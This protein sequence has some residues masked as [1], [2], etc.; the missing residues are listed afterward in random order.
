MLDAL[1]NMFSRKIKIRA[2]M[3][4][5]GEW[6]IG[7]CLEHDIAAQAKTPKDLLY[8]LHRTLI[9]HIVI[10]KKEGIEPFV[11]MKLAPPRFWEMFNEGIPV[12]SQKLKFELPE[13]TPKLEPELHLVTA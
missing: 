2:V 7:Q 10:S 5:E 6:W 9:A 4:K 1:S 11:N 13:N 8:E 12:E 3:F